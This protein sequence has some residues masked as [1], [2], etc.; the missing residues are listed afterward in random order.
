MYTTKTQ[1]TDNTNGSLQ[2]SPG[3]TAAIR[4]MAAIDTYT[5]LHAG[6]SHIVQKTKLTV[7]KQCTPK[8]STGCHIPRHISGTDTVWHFNLG[9]SARRQAQP[10]GCSVAQH[11]PRWKTAHHP[12]RFCRVQAQLARAANE[13]ADQVPIKAA[14][15]TSR[16]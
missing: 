12:L 10:R 16:E 1:G 6:S 7:G 13:A 8:P 3:H 14:L 5:C 4:P 11:G 9:P 2:L 15:C